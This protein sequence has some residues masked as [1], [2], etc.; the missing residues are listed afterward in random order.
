MSAVLVGGTGR[1]F[2]DDDPIA[3]EVDTEDASGAQPWEIDLVWDL[4]LNT[5]ARPGRTLDPPRAGNINTIDEVPDSNWFTNRIGAR[6][7]STADIARGPQTGEGPSGQLTVIRPKQAGAAP[8]FTARDERGDVWFVSL[9]AAG[10]PDAATGAIMVANK[11]FWALGYWQVENYLIAIDPDRIAIADSARMRPPSG[12]NRPMRKS[13]LDAVFAHSHR[14]AD[15]S[16]RAAAGKAIPGTVLGGFKYHGTRPDDPNDIV[17]HEDRRELRGLRVFGA[18]TNLV[19]MKA[20]NTLDTLIEENGRHVVRHYLQDVGSTFGVGAHGLHDYD[21]G[22]EFLYEGGILLRRLVTLGLYRSAWQTARYE[23]VPAIGRFEAEAFEPRT[24]RPRVPTSAYLRARD[25][26]T[27]WAARRVAAFTDEQILAAARA[28]EYS[29]PNAAPYLARILM[30]RRDRIARAYLPA[31]NPL[32][33]FALN[34]QGRLT[35]ANAAEAAGV[36]TAPQGYS[37]TWAHFDNTT[38]DTRPI[39]TETT[40]AGP[41]IEAPPG[42]PTGAGAYIKVQVRAL[43]PPEPSWAVPV[44]VYFRRLADGWKLVGLE[45]RVGG[46][47]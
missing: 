39:G 26:D 40:G 34:A 4:S 17:P 1:K 43:T 2:Y 41:S 24:W 6:P 10:H 8:G 47:D 18:W 19:D 28:G 22:F 23:D 21:E 44:D 37:A 7:L 3:I 14:R 25:D 29:D 20:G 9:D 45:R 38:E 31:I 32:V 5:F 35:F 16:Y 36:A 42:L 11:L 27:F 13:D 46:G 30:A 15:G 33:D 12:S